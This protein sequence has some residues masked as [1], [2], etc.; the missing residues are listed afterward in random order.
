[1]CFNFVEVWAIQTLFY[2][3]IFQ[4]Y[5]KT[6]LHMPQHNMIYM[7]DIATLHCYMAGEKLK[8]C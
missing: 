2:T 7:Y 6:W 8:M 3:E 4:N 5:G 1:M